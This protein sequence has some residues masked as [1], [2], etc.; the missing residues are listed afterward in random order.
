LLDA[1]L[2]AA[3]PL[4]NAGLL[5]VLLVR[6]RL[7]QFSSLALWSAFSILSAGVLYLASGLGQ[8]TY[9]HLYW[10]AEAIDA[11]LQLAIVAQ[12]AWIVFR[13]LRDAARAR[14]LAIALVAS[15][16]TLL[17]ILLTFSVHPFANTPAGVVEIR[18]QL[19]TSI[20]ICST[21]TVVLFFSQ[22]L[23]LYWRS[24]VM[25]VGYGL[26]AWAVVS[27]VLDLLHGYLGREGHFLA[28]EHVRM[29][30]YLGILV[31][32]IVAL[33]RNEPERERPSQEMRDAILHVTDKVSYDLAKVLGTRGKEFH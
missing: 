28:V 16:M 29:L 3:G 17:A 9:A 25:S 21:F 33:W 19:F 15:S 27:L 10:S 18:G 22:R 6:R 31:Y 32:W 23:G 1:A 24:H 20:L 14:W 30:V 26:T 11:L 13:P 7:P 12:V 2:W 5:T 4:V 8:R